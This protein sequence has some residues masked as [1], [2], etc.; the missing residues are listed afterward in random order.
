[1]AAPEGSGSA[2]K[3]ASRHRSSAAAHVTN[4]TNEE[5]T[6]TDIRITVDG[7][8]LTARLDDTAPPRPLLAQLPLT[9]RSRDF[10]RL[11]KIAKLPRP[12]TLGG[13][14]VGADPDVDD[15]GYY[16]PSG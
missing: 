15:L 7:R 3:T 11:E 16:A 9:L 12:L 1:M 10:N 13:A 14:P 8:T 4:T 5:P 2:R 6:V